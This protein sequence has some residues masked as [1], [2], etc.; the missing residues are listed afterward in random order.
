M[1]KPDYNCWGNR[2]LIEELEKRDKQKEETQK[3]E[4]P[5]SESDVQEMVSGEFEFEWTFPT[6]KGEDIDVLIRPEQDSDNE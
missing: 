5:F 1:E 3:L 4:I 2:E 6:D